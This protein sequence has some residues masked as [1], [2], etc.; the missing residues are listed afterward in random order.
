MR[1]MCVS[2]TG[3]RLDDIAGLTRVVVVEA[4]E[5]APLG[6]VL[7][8]RIGLD[9]PFSHVVSLAGHRHVARP[10]TSCATC[11]TCLFCAVINDSPVEMGSIRHAS[12]EPSF[13]NT[14]SAGAPDLRRN[15]GPPHLDLTP[16]SGTC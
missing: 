5:E 14:L 3:R 15:A 8:L 7:A 4:Q 12:Y 10:K 13:R 11:G 6:G 16:T 9:R 1:C 2:M